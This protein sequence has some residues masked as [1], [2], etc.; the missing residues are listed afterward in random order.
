MAGKSLCRLSAASGRG[1]R[2]QPA[3]E[4]GVESEEKRHQG[5][6]KGPH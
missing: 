2:E 4:G 6:G 1:E 5:A 3:E